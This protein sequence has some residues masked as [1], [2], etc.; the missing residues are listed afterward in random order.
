MTTKIQ[1]H[2]EMTGF[3]K[4]LYIVDCGIGENGAPS[5]FLPEK[6]HFLF[7]LHIK[8]AH[9]PLNGDNYLTLV[10]VLYHFTL[11]WPVSFKKPHKV[12]C[13]MS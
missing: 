5:I 12:N 2:E 10:N 9:M 3:P 6:Q 1:K 8:M 4:K 7:L 13:A 11:L